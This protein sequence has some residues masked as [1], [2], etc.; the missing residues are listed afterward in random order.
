MG[1]AAAGP[2][3]VVRIGDDRVR[4]H[5]PRWWRERDPALDDVLAAI[6]GALGVHGSTLTGNVLVRFD[7]LR[8]DPAQVVA[9]LES[10]DERAPATEAV[11]RPELLEADEREA[12]IRGTL[13]LGVAAA[14]LGI[15]AARRLLGHGRAAGSGPLVASAA[16][17]LAEDFHVVAAQ[18]RRETSGPAP[19]DV[20]LKLGSAA[21]LTLAR[22]PVGLALLVLTTLRAVTAARQREQA[23]ER[24]RRALAAV[25]AVAAGSELRLE[26]GGVPP[27]PARV[28]EGSGSALTGSGAWIRVEAGDVIPPGAPVRGGP[29]RVELQPAPVAPARARPVR[30]PSSPAA[31]YELLATPAAVAAALAVG[32]FTRSWRAALTTLVLL[33]PHPAVAGA[34]AAAQSASARLAREGV[35]TGAHAPFVRPPDALL[36]DGIRPLVDAAAADGGPPVASAAGRR[37]IEACRARGVELAAVVAPEPA[38]AS[39]ALDGVPGLP[40]ERGELADAVRRRQARG[41]VV[42]VLADSVAAAGGVAA[43][44]LGLFLSDPMRHAPRGADALVHDLDAVITVLDVTARRRRVERDAV[45]LSAIA[46]AGGL[47][48]ELSGRV[49]L[50][51]ASFELGLVSIATVALAWARLAGGGQAAPAAAPRRLR[52]PGGP[53]PEH[54]GSVSVEEVL[55][56]F[57]TSTRGLTT[58]E[59]RAR[60]RP[61]PVVRE[62]SPFAAALLEQLRSPLT[63]A[64]GVGAALS[65]LMR[66]V[67]DVGLIGAV[68]GANA[69]I[70]AVEES[71]VG[72]AVEALE[73]VAA[74]T[75]HVL[76]DGARVRVSATEVVP[77]DVLLLATGDRVAADAR[78][79]R[80]RGLQVDEAMLTGESLPVPKDAA[81]ATAESRIVL[82]GSDVTAGHGRAIAVAVGVDSRLGATAAALGVV[83]PPESLLNRRLG[84]MVREVLPVALGGAALVVALGML[85]RRPLLGQLAVGAS[86]A[87]AAVPE[88]LPLLARI[89]QAAVGRRLA[90][91]NALVRRLAAVEALGRV[92]VACVDKTGTLTYGRLELQVIQTARVEGGVEDAAVE[93]ELGQVVEAAA[94]ASPRPGSSAAAAHPTDVAVLDAARALGLE[95]AIRPERDREAPFD[96][97]LAFHAAVLGGRLLAKGSPEALARRCSSERVAGEERPLDDDGRRA[98]LSRA[99]ELAR[100]GLRVLLVAEGAGDA[101]PG[102]PTGLTALGLLGIAD[103]LRPTAPDAVA[104]CLAAGVRMVML[105]GD[106]PETARAIA[107]QVGLEPAHE[108]ILTGDLV[109]ALDDAELDARLEQ[110]TVIARI[111]PL[112][113]VRVV[114]SLQRLGHTVAMTGDGVNDA[115]ALRL[116]DVGIAMGRG[117]TE[118]ARQAAD[119]VI[120]DDDV[121]TLVDALVEGRAF[122]GNVRRSLAYLLGGNLGEIGFLVGASAFS[123]Q[124]PLTARQVLAINLGSDVLPALSLVV[125]EPGSRDLSELARE[126]TV[127]LEAP[128]RR[129]I[130]RRGVAVAVP[131]VA[132]YL[133]ALGSGPAAQTV[134]YGAVM[135][136]QLAH[137]LDA[138]V[139]HGSGA[140]G[141]RTV[142]L[143]VALVAATLV[144]PPFR[145]AL[146][147]APL[148]AVGWVLVPAASACSVALERALRRTISA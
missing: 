55:E 108:E 37:L 19:F 26:E 1:G 5:W 45:A 94:I 145:A 140:Q 135:G 47:A 90:A 32:A 121:S 106:H 144:V 120:A 20:G 119:V 95:D 136:C 4:V 34:E 44:D 141:V 67:A 2:L 132:A 139:L 100:R 81:G 138:A 103:G 146:G 83:P 137:A 74:S 60:F 131:S 130:A 133:A 42:A 35:L 7:P 124:P 29:L 58:E 14:G 107:A 30:E 66:S 48:W 101:D 79:F 36:V 86:T 85:R 99:G 52:L 43:A 82:E 72:R 125:Q 93:P 57:V 134:A 62:R 10:L 127:A 3:R 80:T 129:E 116:A 71:R 21:V 40:I 38:R 59:A 11:A 78:L 87:I 18:A 128:L 89:G 105:T 41:Q 104:R 64:L 143:S 63:A 88:G 122:W 76:R 70:G 17:G 12:L 9:T 49:G 73:E 91:R 65:M 117:G 109:A 111:A 102:D 28:L 126:G 54:F 123:R 61:R 24:H 84:A 16:L 8:T 92:D 27:L 118:V 23:R 33:D 148:P 25:S 75:A 98:L 113:K 31:R 114:Q 46:S 39:P 96:A 69:T 142:G 51:Q 68:V 13:V 50:R 22:S 77:G 147:L 15:V 53:Q 110:A 56:A 97:A 115:P 6:P 112:E